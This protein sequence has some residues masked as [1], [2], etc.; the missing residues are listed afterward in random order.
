MRVE[1]LLLQEFE[2]IKNGIPIKLGRVF[3]N[4]SYRYLY[5]VLKLYEDELYHKVKSLI[6]LGVG[7]GDVLYFE[8]HKIILTSGLF[9]LV[10]TKG[11]Y[12]NGK[13]K[14]PI[15]AQK[16]FSEQLEW[17]RQSEHLIDDYIYDDPSGHMH[18]IVLKVPDDVPHAVRAFVLGKY[19]MIYTETQAK[20]I[21][22]T[23]S[24]EFKIVTNDKLFRKEITQKVNE[25]VGT[26]YAEDDLPGL[27][28]KPRFEWEIFKDRKPIN[29][30]E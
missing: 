15:N 25:L 1:D 20:R 27:T 30:G 19:D 3:L 4:K 23:Q 8:K 24:R 16:I 6:K 5:P 13:H 14:N 26:R 11:I 21:F 12:A 7:I 9:I 28:S 2:N 17:F 10:D 29:D 18:M 22:D